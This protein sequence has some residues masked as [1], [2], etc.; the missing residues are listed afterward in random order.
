MDHIPA[1]LDVR[2]Q[3]DMAVLICRNKQFAVN[4]GAHLKP[5]EHFDWPVYQHVAAAAVSFWQKYGTRPTQRYFMGVFDALLRK[6]SIDANLYEGLKY[7]VSTELEHSIEDE[8]YVMD[9]A[10]KWLTAQT[11]M[12]LMEKAINSYKEGNLEDITKYLTQGS[13]VGINFGFSPDFYVEST[14]DVIQQRKHVSSDGIPTGLP[15]DRHFQH[16]GPVRESVNVIMAGTNVGKTGAMICIGKNC[17]QNGYKVAHITLETRKEELRLRY[18]AAF[19]SISKGEVPFNPNAVQTTVKSLSDSFG[20]TL[21]YDRFSPGL[22]T[23]SQLSAWLNGLSSLGFQ[24]DV[25]LVDS[26]DDLVPHDR[27]TEGEYMRANLVYMGL[28]NVAAKFNLVVW[29]TTQGN[30]DSLSAETVTLDMVGDSIRKVQRADCVICIC[31]TL[32][33]SVAE[34]A[35]GRLYIGKQRWGPKNISEPVLMDMSK[36]LLYSPNPALRS[37]M[38]AVK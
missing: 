30:R 23:L 37:S 10:T 9:T 15:I 34:P 16:G 7:F 35:R 20:D 6:K 38:L 4:M 29:T 14:E 11:Q 24:P 12:N 25:L 32:A 19:S 18:D 28:M 1:V 36:D 2:F 8:N 22:F 31:Q 21:V 3:S 26:A 5:T 17:V 13:N 27:F 33:E